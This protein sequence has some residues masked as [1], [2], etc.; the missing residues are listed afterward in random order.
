MLLAAAALV[1]TTLAVA[2][3]PS[4]SSLHLKFATFDPAQG[5]VE[6]PEALRAD[7]ATGLW[8]VQFGRAPTDA[9]REAV[10]RAGGEVLR[11]LPENAYVVR[12][13]AAEAAAVRAQDPVRYVGAYHPA[14]R[15]DP[16]L[17]D[18]L[19]QGRD[20]SGDGG[21]GRYYIVV[22]DKHNDKPALAEGIRALGG[23]VRF[24]HPGSL[25][26][27]VELTAAQ[28]R[29]AANLDQVLWI[30]RWTAVE[31]DMD[32][33]RIQ[34]GGNYVESQG[35]FTGTGV[36]A[37]IYEGVEAT[38][39]DFT[40][41][42]TAVASGGAS[43][44]GHATAG[45]V[46]GNGT[47]NPA[48]RGMAPDAG[49][50]YTHAGATASRYQVVRD[51]VNIH[52]VSH[53]TASWGGGRT[54][55][56]TSTSA[57]SD[58]II[59]D[60]DIAWTQS[61]S[62]AG[63]QQSRPQAWAKNIFS[64]GGV[65]HRNNSF[66]GDDSWAAGNAST[67]P[68]ADGRIK[69]TLC[70]YYDGIGTSDRTGSAGYSNGNWTSSFGG[71]SGATPIV[72]GHNVLA[73]EMFTD[74][75]FGNTVR[76]PGG[77]RHSNRP[78]F[79][80]LK[81]LQVASAAQYSFTASS[82]DNR[83]EHQ[84]WGFPDLRRM[85]DYRAKTYI[86]DESSVLSQGQSRRWDIQVGSGEPDLKICMTYAD[87]AANP[88][89]SIARVNDLS[90]RVVDP[91]GVTYWG[92][93]GLNGGVWSV[94]GGSEDSINPIECVFVRNPAAGLWHV[95]VIATL[96]VQDSHVETPGVDAD[97]GLVV[98]GGTGP[99][100]GSPVL[101]KFEPYGSGCVGGTCPSIN[102][103]GGTL[104]G[105]YPSFE[106]AY[107]VQNTGPLTIDG[108]ELFCQTN[109]GSRPVSALVYA[110]AGGQP[111]G[112]PTAAGILNVGPTA[113]F[114]RATIAPVTVNGN[115]WIAVDNT[116]GQIAV[117]HLASGNSTST[118]R[119]PTFLLSQWSSTSFDRPAFRLSC[120]AA[121]PTIGNSGLATVNFPFDVT[122][123]QAPANAFSLLALGFSDTQL[124]VGT[125]L[126]YALPGATG[127][128]LLVSWDDWTSTGTDGSGNAGVTLNVPNVSSLTG[129]NVFHQWLISDPA[130]NALGVVV[131]NAAK[132]TIGN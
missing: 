102:A 96:V 26:F 77:S 13:D 114:Y 106:F 2:Q 64:I 69:P 36:N 31:F 62:N 74:G 20:P 93:N 103:A 34:G 128:D 115:F 59:F 42:V 85:W 49:K 94:P 1:S 58:D 30:D 71:T 56:Y 60:H 7:G 82:S 98:S 109:G 17:R 5:E 100:G 89:A 45:I 131:S 70:A 90:L 22:A 116:S 108:F 12:M 124:T 79:T 111:A 46:F 91:N 43:T 132:S 33:A 55:Q 126:P 35:G 130:A 73:I 105:L 6:V 80:T 27:E 112:L 65:A 81:A 110:D 88:A 38:H 92:N 107:L 52:N 72:A 63:N 119:R 117:S 24:D 57:D 75:V 53:T 19:A 37:H 44:H 61:Q 66:A 127:C 25:L 10:R 41:G 15:L 95:E 68:A 104:T 123:S 29:S 129:I 21:V 8:V 28:L 39:P 14:Y 40:G 9:L 18:A 51:L 54:T 118:Y 23:K 32:N 113:G 48:V 4:R 97:Y 3:S 125:P 86:V 83:R 87:P 47:S 84:G 122:L 121:P 50:F 78:K 99:G 11:Y 67:G 16:E 76:N 101:G 120:G